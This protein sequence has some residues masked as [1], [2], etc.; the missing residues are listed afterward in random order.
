MFTLLEQSTYMHAKEGCYLCL[1]AGPLV[2]TGMQ[3]EGEGILAVCTSCV[4]DLARKANIGD[5]D[6]DIEI[7]QL[8]ALVE[9][10]AKD[11]TGYKR[12]EKALRDKLREANAELGLRDT[13][14]LVE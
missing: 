13:G 11:L 3:I 1:R 10:Q 4:A 2:D 9:N 12:R 8:S 6:A 14:T 7:E 5:P